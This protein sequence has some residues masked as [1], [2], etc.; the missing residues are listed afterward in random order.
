MLVGPGDLA[1]SIQSSLEPGT[2]EVCWRQD[3]AR[4]QYVEN[5]VKSRVQTANGALTK[6]VAKESSSFSI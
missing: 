5:T 1:T 3:P 6:Q 4:R 2:V